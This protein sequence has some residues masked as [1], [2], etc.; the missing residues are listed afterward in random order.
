[1]QERLCQVWE[2]PKLS[3]SVAKLDYDEVCGRLLVR[4]RWAI[5]FLF[6]P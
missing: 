2:M 3:K 1:M 6:T 5:A 4:F